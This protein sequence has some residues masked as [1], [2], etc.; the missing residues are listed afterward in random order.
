[1]WT[2]GQRLGRFRLDAEIGQ[3]SHGVVWLATDT[4]LSSQ[5]AI[6]ILH[7]WL[8]DDVPV[9]ER[10]KRELL[11]ARRI[12]HPGICRLFDLH[13]EA[14]AFFITMD[15]IEG[16][17]LLGILKR[18]GRLS[19]LRAVQILRGVCA[20][21]SAA[22][23]AGV[24]H[25]DLKPAN[26]IVKHGD[27]PMILDF[28]TA[29]AQDVSRVTRPGTAVGSMRFI[30]P[31]IFTGTAPSAC[32][33]VYSL[34]VVAYVALAG[35]LP[36]DA[37][38]GAGDMLEKIRNQEPTRLDI[39]INISAH[40]A[41]VVARA[42]YRD[43]AARISSALRLAEALA[44]VEAELLA[45]APAHKSEDNNDR[46]ATASSAP[47]DVN[48]ASPSLPTPSQ[49]TSTPG[50]GVSDKTTSGPA[51]AVIAV[52]PLS[53]MR[54][55]V[56]VTELTVIV[57]RAKIARAT[58]TP[59]SGRRRILLAA[60]TIALAIVVVFVAM[61]GNNASF[62]ATF[63][64]GAAAVDAGGTVLAIDAGA[65]EATV[66]GAAD[67]GLLLA[68]V[69]DE[70]ADPSVDVDPRAARRA[71]P[72]TRDIGAVKDLLR[73]RGFIVGDLPA[74]EQLL[75]KARS[76]A[77]ARR[78]SDVLRDLA[79]ARLLIEGQQIDRAFVLVKLN[80]FNARFD[81]ATQADLANLVTPL[82][83][84]AATSFAAGQFDV[85]NAKLNRAFT[86][87]AP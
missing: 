7:P 62:D 76:A 32:T 58:A 41:D 45:L 64:A 35:R 69:A 38:A 13:E 11:L 77:A 46:P 87:L 2:H 51:P 1:M 10:F 30:A 79:Q 24:I 53:T 49:P 43:P 57:A 14:G 84:E 82:A 59:T 6:K 78:S 86:L 60:V 33:D 29:T 31:E 4:A 68:F 27:Q 67:A 28:G 3:G 17:T 36:Y 81:G 8:T 42:M 65:R 61:P 52:A 80:R 18:E 71:S 22:H 85:A 37:A 23:Q 34:G 15:Y 48:A 26:I 44:A 74:A 39:D 40:L 9:R 25:R 63:D 21:L 47:A 72:Y 73:R 75:A 70:L 83:K 66:M 19:P 12:A 5:V 16:E 54:A 50:V 56:P 20:A 55:A